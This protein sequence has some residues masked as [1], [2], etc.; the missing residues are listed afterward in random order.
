M[1]L[2]SKQ[3]RIAPLEPP[4]DAGT[5]EVLDRLGPP[6]GLFRV[7]ARRP[8]LARGVAD[9]GRYYFSRQ[10][11]LTVRQRELVIDRTT[12]LCGAAYEWGVHLATFAEKAGLHDDQIRSLATGGPADECW[13]ASDRAVLAAVDEL[14]ATHDLA[15]RTWADLTDAIG[16]DGALD[17]LLVCGW[18]HAISFTVRALRL[19]LEPGT[20]G[21][22]SP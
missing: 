18:Y 1:P 3:P 19:P 12:A 9:W 8:A 2:K 7:W 13:D 22:D 21:P 10:S 20:T 5:A 15:D 14:H 6:I 17:L 16:E 4:F 11:A